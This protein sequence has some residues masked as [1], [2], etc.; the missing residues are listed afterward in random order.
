[1]AKIRV[2]LLVGAWIETGSC[3]SYVSRFDVAL[4]VGAWIETLFD[5]YD[6]PDFTVALL[7]GAWIETSLLLIFSEGL[8]CRTPRGCVD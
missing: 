5:G 3:G 4:L 1:M 7:V 2:A 8:R 6:K